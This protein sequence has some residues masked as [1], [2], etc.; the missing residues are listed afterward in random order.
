MLKDGKDPEVFRGYYLEGSESLDYTVSNLTVDHAQCGTHVPLGWWRGVNI[1]HNAIFIE[2]F[3]DELA[4]AAGQDTLDFR[5][6]LMGK[7]PKALAV[8]DA[9]VKKGGWATQRTSGRH[10]GLS[11]FRVSE[12]Y[13]AAL[14][15]ISVG[16]SGGVKVHKVTVAIDP[17]IAVNPAQIERQIASGVVFGLSALFLQGLTIQ[18]GRME[19][20]N[21]D[22]YDSMRISQ[23]PTIEAI[24][25]PS[26]GFWGGVGEAPTC[27][28]APAV[29]N[30]YFAA[31]GKR[32][33]SI[34][35]KNHGIR[36]V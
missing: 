24:V 3:I 11:Q 36:M 35:L 30:A 1:N 22:S 2:C 10:L 25:M 28:A 32:I 5:R 8:L 13:I 14:A 15:E 33:R 4:H 16:D 29:L 17:G 18:G 19:Q 23:M 9:V 6:K 12:S 26:G 31:T 27:V 34:P 7:R 21:F 20:D